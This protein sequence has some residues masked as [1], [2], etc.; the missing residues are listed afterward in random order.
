MTPRAVVSHMQNRPP[1]GGLFVC[2]IL[3]TKAW[4]GCDRWG[5]LR[6]IDIDNR[7]DQFARIPIV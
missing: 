7:E 4:M 2:C 3:E 6:P 5:D 1:E